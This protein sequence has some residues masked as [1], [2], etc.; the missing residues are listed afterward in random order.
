MAVNPRAEARERL[1]GRYDARV[2]ESS[3][4]AV[5]EP[6]WFADDPV[7]RDDPPGD[8][9]RVSPVGR[10]G[11]RWRDLVGDDPALAAWCSER[12]LAGYRRLGVAPAGLVSTRVALQRLA[13]RVVSPAREHANG[14][15]GL[16]YT[17][18]GF[19]TPFF[20]EDTQLRVVG[21][22][23]V[24]QEE[25]RERSAQITTIAEMVRHV[26][27]DLLPGAE[28]DG[29][30]EGDDTALGV[31]A[32]ASSFLGDW[33]GFATSV[34]EELREDVGDELEPS[35]VQLWPEHFDLSFEFGV[36]HEG[37]RAGYGASPGDEL[38]PEPY[39]YV[40]PWG[41]T[42]PGELWQASAFEGAELSYA[43]LLAADDQR[44]LALRFLSRRA[45]AL[46]HR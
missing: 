2:L 7:G 23:L 26:G 1:D 42:P 45:V 39:L 25:D 3:P 28:R 14:K 33:Y 40:V 27:H 13:E 12:W 46:E 31:D 20:G 34:L 30:A 22:R 4:P 19:G 24:V 9:P 36:E 5:E 38:H 43:E 10:T 8:L 16:R 32:V 35:R 11:I 37:R 6:P 21:D 29:T 44:A 41:D 17:R 18:G 15:I